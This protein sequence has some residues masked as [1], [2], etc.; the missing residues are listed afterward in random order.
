MIDDAL[1]VHGGDLAA[2]S[3]RH[4]VPRDEWLDLSTGI[5]PTPYPVSALP[6]AALQDSL[7]DAA[8]V[9][10][11]VAAG[12]AIVAAPGASSSLTRPSAMPCPRPVWPP[13]PEFRGFW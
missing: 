4:G 5:N 2:A 10:Y 7:I 6:D 13:S 12:A 8:R 9:G 11:G 1:P 3:A